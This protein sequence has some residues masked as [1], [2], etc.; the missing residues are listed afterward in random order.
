MK[1]RKERGMWERKG[2]T[3][4]R[5]VDE[6]ANTVWTAERRSMQGNEGKRGSLRE[7]RQMEESDGFNSLK[8]SSERKRREERGRRESDKKARKIE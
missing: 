5:R 3:G 8:V 6:I 2:G 1:E 7:R 4:R